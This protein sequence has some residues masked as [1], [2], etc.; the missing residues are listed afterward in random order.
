V[1]CTFFART[2]AHRRD[3]ERPQASTAWAHLPGNADPIAFDAFRKELVLKL[4]TIAHASTP[5]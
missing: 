5:S 2:Q 1:N 3:V 4:R